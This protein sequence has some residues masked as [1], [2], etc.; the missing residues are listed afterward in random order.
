MQMNLAVR[1]EKSLFKINLVLAILAWI[2]LI[3]GTL[4]LGLIYIL[5]GFLFY[6]FA[7]S[8]LIAHLKGSA[9]KVSATQYPDLF[10]KITRACDKLKMPVPTA[11]LMNGNGVIN[12][13]AT[14]FMRKHYIVLL[15]DIVDAFEKQDASIDF[16]IGH[17]LGHI[18]RK[19]LVWWPILLPVTCLPLLMPAYRRACESTCDQY[20]KFCSAS[21]EDAVRGMALLAAGSKRWKS[22]SAASFTE[23]IKESGGFWMS[24]HEITASYPWL[25]KRVALIEGGEAAAGTFPGRNPLAWLIGLFCPG[26]LPGA[27]MPLLVIYLA[28]IGFAI[29]VPNFM[30]YQEKLKHGSENSQNAP[31]TNKWKNPVSGRELT[32]PSGFREITS[33][34]KSD[35]LVG[36]FTLDPDLNLEQVIVE[37]MQKKLDFGKYVEA[38]YDS[39][40]EAIGK[41]Y[42]ISRP[43]L[44]NVGGFEIAEFGFTADADGFAYDNV[45]RAWS[46]DGI[47]FW[48]V[49]STDRKDSESTRVASQRFRDFL[50]KETE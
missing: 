46:H 27:F 45:I 23:Q 43:A 44:S 20:G 39:K 49:V 48:Q 6:L 42:K 35:L 33:Q 21:S 30:K 1:Q 26:F 4:G 32:L 13:F 25:S 10:E 16:Y 9:V 28:I 3:G 37:K 31:S 47:H 8:A 36:T 24:F 29:A 18:H 2:A 34:A 50:L 19:H 41:K 40:I 15:S 38:L 5:G 17:E 22:F 11:Y 12:A 7:H 14:K